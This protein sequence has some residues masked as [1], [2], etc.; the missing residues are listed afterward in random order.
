MSGTQPVP[1]IFPDTVRGV[2][3]YKNHV[4][5]VQHRHPG[6]QSQGAW[7]LPGGDIEETDNAS[8]GDALLRVLYEQLGV[9]A[10]LAGKVGIWAQQREGLNRHHHVFHAE[11][12]TMLIH[13]DPAE[14]VSAVWFAPQA[15][16]YLPI[17]LGWED[18]AIQRVFAG[19]TLG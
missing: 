10:T 8:L 19:L 17:M 18:D 9:F 2:L 1:Y 11:V 6:P 13:P 14:I 16:N 5:L 4:L 15:V 12:Q 3:T 7:E